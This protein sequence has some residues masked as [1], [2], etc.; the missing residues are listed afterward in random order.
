M[1]G[2]AAAPA[3]AAYNQDTCHVG[4][5][6]TLCKTADIPAHSTQHWIRFAAY[7]AC[8]HTNFRVVDSANGNVVY[9][10]ND[11]GAG[12]YLDPYTVYG[13][14]SSYHVTVY[15]SCLGSYGWIANYS[16]ATPPLH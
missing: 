14:Y 16:E 4:P 6:Q 8:D 5:F 11:V 3:H 9:Y 2:L 15:N 12:I 13:L 1:L 10:V 7:A